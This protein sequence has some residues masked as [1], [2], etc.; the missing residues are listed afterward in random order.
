M[1]PLAISNLPLVSDLGILCLTDR[2]V[3]ETAIQTISPKFKA[4]EQPMA[5]KVLKWFGSGVNL[6]PAIFNLMAHVVM[7]AQQHGVTPDDEAFTRLTGAI[8]YD[9]ANGSPFTVTGDFFCHAGS[10]DQ[11]L[12]SLMAT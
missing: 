10:V 9:N 5:E 12:R 4:T 1:K 6:N 3:V 8:E 2:S 7:L 11:L